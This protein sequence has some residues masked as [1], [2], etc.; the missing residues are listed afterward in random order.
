MKKIRRML[1]VCVVVLIA[2]CSQNMNAE[3]ESS[4]S[5]SGGGL[6]YLS[7]SIMDSNAGVEEFKSEHHASE[8]EDDK[9]EPM[10]RKLVKN[11][12]LSFETD[13]LQL[14]K[15]QIDA[16]VLQFGGYISSEESYTAT[17]RETVDVT[18]RV[19]GDNFDGFMAMATNG[20][21]EFDSRSISVNDVTEEYIDVAARIETKKELKKRFVNLLDRAESIKKIFEIEREISALQEEIESFE[22]RLMQLSSTV[23]FSTITISYYKLLPDMVVEEENEFVKAFG[24]G[25]DIIVVFCIALTHLWPFIILLTIGFIIYRQRIRRKQTA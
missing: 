20:V 6:D 2:G 3:M 13:S 9:A 8:N 1:V 21:G 15:R 14:R 12:F 23:A 4:P 24:N 10:K 18:I 16:A 5:M 7:E 17:G 25:W 22:A 19:P 11:A